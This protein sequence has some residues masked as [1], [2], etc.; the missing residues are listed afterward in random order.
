MNIIKPNILKSKNDNRKGYTY[1]LPNKLRVLIFQDED[2]DVACVSMLVKIGYFQDE[3][4][5]MAHFLE[6][7]LFNGT[8]KFPDENQFSSFISDNN[9][10]SNAWT[11]HNH[12]CY[13][14]TLSQ[15]GLNKSLELFSSF[16]TCPL[17][18]KDCVDREKEAVNSEH[19]KNI[20]DDGWRRQ[21]ILK[22]ATAKNHWFSKFGC[23]SN[24]TLN[25]KDIHL[26][27]RDF[28]EKYY[29]S[30]LM[31][32]VVVSK[33]SI[34]NVK[35]VIDTNFSDIKL[36]NMDMNILI[37]ETK[38]LNTPTLIKYVP[39]E[40][41]KKIILVWE[42][43]FYRKDLNKSPF[44]FF[45]K[46]ANNQQKKSIYD[47]LISKEYA[48]NFQC[49][50][51]EIIHDK[52][53]FCA[54]ISLTP[55]GEKNKSYI[56][57]LFN[58]FIQN[59]L[60]NIDN[61]EELYNENLKLI[62]YNFDFFEKKNPIDFITEINSVLINY[63]INPEHILLIDIMQDS[64]KNIKNNLKK[65]L[66][67]LTF[68]KAVIIICSDKYSKYKLLEF[69][70]YGTKYF[71]DNKKYNFEKNVEIP[72]I[73]KLNPYISVSEKMHNFSQKIPKLFE[74]ENS[75]IYFQQNTEF[76]T[77]D[78]YLYLCINNIISTKDVKIYICMI[79]YLTSLVKQINNEIYL[80]GTALYNI[81][82]NYSNGDIYI[83]ISG[84]YEKFNDV[85]NLLLEKLLNYDIISNE[86]FSMV[87]FE[88]VKICENELYANPYEKLSP[89]FKKRINKTFYNSEDVLSV[90][91]D[92]TLDNIKNIFKNALLINNIISYVYGNCTEE[93]FEEIKK[94]MNKIPHKLYIGN[95]KN[96]HNISKKEI[97]KIMNKNKIEEN[98]ANGYYIFI[99][100]FNY[101]NID[102]WIKDYCCLNVLHNLI[103]TEY[104]DQL[105]T[106]EMFGY[107]VKS[108]IIQTGSKTSPSFYYLFMVQSP[109][110][111][112]IVTTERT[113]KFIKDFIFE[114]NKIT[115]D[116]INLIKE[117]FITSIM[118]KFNNANEYVSYIFH[119]EIET[120]YLK[121]NLREIIANNTKNITKK[122]LINFYETK[123]L[124]NNKKLVLQLD[125]QK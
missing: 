22:V 62:K 24:E 67:S 35:K 66:E 4:S 69:P 114:L 91:N 81:S 68:D 74:T 102:S 46:F 108:M 16:F 82:I 92:I 25:I 42:V 18:K 101:K 58:N 51:R 78:I 87:K 2:I 107:V 1:E 88:I 80:L 65:L 44:E 99:D 34:E 53:I 5:G 123:I 49:Y 52:C 76:K 45:S 105:R 43:D 17:L 75:K 64:Y 125:K 104:F 93:Q 57:T 115:E 97:I 113:E 19:K 98:Y 56:L 47:I 26:K 29:S 9:G 21:E 94:I 71:I 106:K 124:N 83:I 27:V 32:L 38:I 28:F 23:G 116:K 20:N 73:P 54:D 33:D 112:N 40:N 36:K 86:I 6:H 84:N 79:L 111:S 120:E 103:S 63:E 60:Q 95:N 77:P 15:N 117:S 55:L 96:I 12:T 14:Y 3:I 70:H 61:L 89:L 72:E 10:Y 122:D 48:T 110:K 30:D 8:E 118:S 7:M 119:A 37:Q 41:D 121:Y 11:A 31:T 39:I 109:S 90:I 100:E 13:Y 50:I 85:L 59:V